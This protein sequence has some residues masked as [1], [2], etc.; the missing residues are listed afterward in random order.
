MQFRDFEIGVSLASGGE[1]PF[2]RILSPAFLVI[3]WPG[4]AGSEKPARESDKA[5]L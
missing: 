1:K 5:G 2:F 3:P 4:T